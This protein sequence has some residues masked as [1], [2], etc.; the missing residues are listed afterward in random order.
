MATQNKFVPAFKVNGQS[1]RVHHG[2]KDRFLKVLKRMEDAVASGDTETQ[3][4]YFRL[5][6]QKG[7]RHLKAAF[8]AKGII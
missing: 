4:Y 5:M 1:I 8:A 3:E 2:D 7:H 6:E